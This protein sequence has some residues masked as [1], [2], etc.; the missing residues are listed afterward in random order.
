MKRMR[1]KFKK[2]AREAGGKGEDW[3]KYQEEAIKKELEALVG[4]CLSNIF[5]MFTHLF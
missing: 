2:E 5:S 3:K 4:A 1:R